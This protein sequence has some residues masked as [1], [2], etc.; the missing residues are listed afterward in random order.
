VGGSKELIAAIRLPSE[1]ITYCRER[2][3]FM[4]WWSVWDDLAP[5]GCRGGF[6]ANARII[7]F[8]KDIDDIDVFGMPNVWM[9]WF[10]SKQPGGKPTSDCSGA[11]YGGA[12]LPLG[13]LRFD[14]ER[15][16]LLQIHEKYGG[17]VDRKARHVIIPPLK[18]PS[19]K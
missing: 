14:I 10:Q 11:I 6:Y 15:R 4:E 12:K 5:E 16:G 7:V 17:E 3:P 1:G 19:F 2:K 9:T 8:G 13:F 18:H